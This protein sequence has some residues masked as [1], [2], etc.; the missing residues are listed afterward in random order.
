MPRPRVRALLIPREHGAWG[1]LLVPL[2]TGA[3]VGLAQARQWEHL[4]LFATAALALFWLRTP[5]EVALGTSPVRAQSSAETNSLL[6][7]IAGLGSVA[8][9]CL[10]R[11][12]WHGDND[13]LWLI[14]GV[15]A[16]AFAAQVLVRR[17]GRKSRMP[18]QMIGAIGLTS[19]AAGAYYVVTGHID[20]GLLGLWLANWIF[21][22]NQIHFVQLRIHA[23]RAATWAEKF[24]RGQAFFLGQFAMVAALLAAWNARLLPA[25][26]LVAFLPVLV[27]GLLWFV[28]GPQPLAVRRLG[29]TE[30]SHAAAFGVLLVLGFLRG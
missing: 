23:A 30:L 11:L 7:A 19:T 6:A 29:W 9:L 1:M 10:A 2:F 26:A 14:G 8:M 25:L 4:G 24:S 3:C 5:L 12:L 17:T 13:G 21:T 22:G 18:A 27:R 15:A 28:P 20:R 16:V